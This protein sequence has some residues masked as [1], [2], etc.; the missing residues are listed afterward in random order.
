MMVMRPSA[1]AVGGGLI[2][3]AVWSRVAD[4]VVA[5]MRSEPPSFGEMFTRPPAAARPRKSSLAM[6]AVASCRGRD[7]A[8]H[9]SRFRRL[10][11]L[12]PMNHEPPAGDADDDR[13][14][15]RRPEAVDVETV[16]QHGDKADHRGIRRSGKRPRVTMVIRKVDGQDRPHHGVATPAGALR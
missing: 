13:C 14:P 6:K 5:R 9:Q 11:G 2:A 16:E 1:K 7:T 8:G 4:L 12:G 3:A 15:D 10:L